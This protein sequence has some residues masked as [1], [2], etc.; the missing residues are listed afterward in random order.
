M[1]KTK[2][3]RTALSLEYEKG[4][5]EKLLNF[6]YKRWQKDPLFLHSIRAHEELVAV[7]ILKLLFWLER[8][9]V[10]PF[11]AAGQKKKESAKQL[12]NNGVETF[13]LLSEKETFLRIYNKY[14]DAALPRSNVKLSLINNE[15]ERKKIQRRIS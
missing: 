11:H 12:V 14:V 1:E 15:A 4:S 13:N 5:A 8:L 3:L 10:A 2:T 6:V 9:D 7:A